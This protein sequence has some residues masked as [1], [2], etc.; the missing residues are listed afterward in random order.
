MFGYF[1]VFKSIFLDQFKDELAAGRKLPDDRLDL[2]DHFRR[3]HFLFR[4]MIN[5]FEFHCNTIDTDHWIFL[6]FMKLVYRPVF[7]GCKKIELQIFD[8]IKLLTL[9]PDLQ[10]YIGNDFF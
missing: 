2:A 8:L 1:L 7:D 10:K 3:D 6:L 4:V 9:F 5:S